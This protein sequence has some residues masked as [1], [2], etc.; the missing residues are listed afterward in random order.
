MASYIKDEIKAGVVVVTTLLVISVFVILVG[1]GLF[2][3]KYDI[4][5]VKL[6]D[7]AGIDVG[8]QVRL[9]GMRVGKITNIII[10]DTAKDPLTIVLG[11]NKGTKFYKGTKA[12]I[13]QIGFVGEI[14]MGLSLGDIAE[15]KIEPGSTI[16]SEETVG[17]G[18]LLIKLAK[19]T[20]SLNK[21]LKDVDA[22]F[23]KQNQ[24]QV[25]DLL[26]NTNKAVIT[27]NAEI[28]NVSHSLTKTFAKMDGVLKELNEL[29]KDNK[30]EVATLLKTVTQEVRK[31]GTL[32]EAFEKIAGSLTKTSNSVN[33][34]VDDQSQNLTEVMKNI[35][36][37]LE[38]LQ[39]A[40]QEIKSKP[41]SFLYKEK[42]NEN[43]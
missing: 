6:K 36:T 15:S 37:T 38:D 29:L 4:Y 43:E 42:E 2:R 10:P 7:V 41:W 12:M 11:I 39:G 22:M 28:Q 19:A 21:L 26:A 23:G 17:F 3:G 25:E 9:G 14:Y 24:K 32:V 40:L 18:D 5:Y 8:S 27:V 31:I 16:P 30:G 20:E 34:L 35:T 13:S 33:N 1:G